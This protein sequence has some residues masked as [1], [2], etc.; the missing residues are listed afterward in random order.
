M[1]LLLYVLTAW[2]VLS[3]PAALFFGRAVSPIGKIVRRNS[4]PAVNSLAPPLEVS[5]TVAAPG[6]SRSQYCLGVERA[7]ASP[8][9]QRSP[10][11]SSMT[12]A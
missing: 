5:S 2:V 11:L 6:E 9:G 4:S 7:T 12:L 8:K 1:R 10:P 3:I